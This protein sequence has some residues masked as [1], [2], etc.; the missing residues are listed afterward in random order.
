MNARCAKLILRSALALGLAASA[1]AGAQEAPVASGHLDQDIPVM[2]KGL[3]C[4]QLRGE[5]FAATGHGRLS[6]GCQQLGTQST[7]EAMPENISTPATESSSATTKEGRQTA[8][9]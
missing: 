7:R 9:W 3:V 1:A 6:R 2:P 4:S 5:D 8:Y